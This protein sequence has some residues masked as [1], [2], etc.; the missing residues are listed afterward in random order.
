MG[1]TIAVLGGGNGAHALAGDLALRGY[2]VRMY[3]DKAFIGKLK[4]LYANGEGGYKNILYPD[5]ELA[6]DTCR[7]SLAESYKIRM[8]ISSQD[9]ESED[10]RE[11]VSP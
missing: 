6:S 3:E 4:V 10:E 11:V 1:K 5:I 2:R 7:N 9:E 8:G